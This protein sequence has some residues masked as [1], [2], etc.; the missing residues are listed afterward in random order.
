MA[1]DSGSFN[2]P[3]QYIYKS[4]IDYL[5]IKWGATQDEHCLC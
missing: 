5:M 4:I 2:F 3:E 1:L